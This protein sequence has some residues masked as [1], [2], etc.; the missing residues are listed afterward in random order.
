ML[1]YSTGFVNRTHSTVQ[2]L[3]LSIDRERKETEKGGIPGGRW[4]GGTWRE[5]GRKKKT[6]HLGNFLCGIT[7]DSG[8]MF[9]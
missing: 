7:E 4:G 2:W 5:E 6:I 8:G 9:L 1:K 3:K